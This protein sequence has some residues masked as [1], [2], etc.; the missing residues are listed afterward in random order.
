MSDFIIVWSGGE[1]LPPRASGGWPFED[2]GFT[3]ER[4]IQPTPPRAKWRDPMFRSQVKGL[5]RAGQTQ[6][7]IASNLGVPLSQ[8]HRAL[9]NG[10][11]PHAPKGAT[12]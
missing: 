10:K 8:V 11:R 9:H 1:L 12:R 2:H 5:V 3:R 4:T 7:G 6:R